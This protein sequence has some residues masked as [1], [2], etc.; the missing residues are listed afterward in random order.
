MKIRATIN[1]EERLLE[2]PRAD[3]GAA[4]TRFDGDAQPAVDAVEVQPGVFSVLLGTRSLQ[5]FLEES[6]NGCYEV[7]V[8][9]RRF[10][11]SLEDPRRYRAGRRAGD[12][13]GPQSVVAPMPGKVVKVLVEPGAA[14]EAG[15]G[16]VVVEA[17]KM[18]NEIKATKTGVV[19]A[20]HVA[21][22]ASVAAGEALIVVE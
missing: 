1:G 2:I 8:E 15:Q 12:A 6:T 21:V 14:V 13:G 20:V 16:L 5:V 10:E 17:M 18:Q 9:G 22:G 11:V 4:A 3:N 7:V 19:A